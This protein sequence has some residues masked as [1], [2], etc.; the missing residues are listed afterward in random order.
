M[1]L[2]A[3]VRE[4][5]DLAS[6]LPDAP[7]IGLDVRP[8]SLPIQGDAGRL[9]QVVLNLLANAIEHATA[10]GAIEVVV[11]RADGHAE[12]RV[13]DHGPGIE[14]EDLAYLFDAYTRRTPP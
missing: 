7:P 5:V 3:V 1:D 10:T 12:V 11:R 13:R 6:V 8:A 14:A 9:E 4:A 2:A